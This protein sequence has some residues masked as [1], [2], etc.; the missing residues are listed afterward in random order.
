[1]VASLPIP[2]DPWLSHCHKASQL[3]PDMWGQGGSGRISHGSAT[4]RLFYSKSFI[5]SSYCSHMARAYLDPIFGMK[6]K[7]FKSVE[8]HHNE[9]ITAWPIHLNYQKHF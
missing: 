2:L 1:M 5:A 6:M 3:P 8:P 9:I 4:P 7:I